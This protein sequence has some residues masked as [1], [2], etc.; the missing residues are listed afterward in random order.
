MIRSLFYTEKANGMKI[1][2]Q[3]IKDTLEDFSDSL[4]AEL[5][6]TSKIFERHYPDIMTLKNAGVSVSK[7]IE[8]SSFSGNQATFSVRL[9]QAKAKLKASGRLDEVVIKSVQETKSKQQNTPED[10]DD[11]YW[12]FLRATKINDVDKVKCISTHIKNVFNILVEAGWNI[13][14][15]SEFCS[16]QK[17][18]KSNELFNYDKFDLYISDVIKRLKN[19]AN[20]N[21]QDEIISEISYKQYLIDTNNE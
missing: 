6:S 10:N 18:L 1:T 14:S 13:D 11:F 4:D 20:R 9:S 2:E 12:S 15:I 8:L 5:I 19:P 3:Y 16:W 17:D 7:M 21:K